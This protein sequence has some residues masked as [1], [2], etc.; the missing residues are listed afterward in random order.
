MHGIVGIMNNIHVS[1]KESQ[2]QEHGWND[3][4]L[5]NWML[6]IL[7]SHINAK[8]ISHFSQ[9]VPI[10]LSSWHSSLS[11]ECAVQIT[12]SLV[13]LNPS[14]R[15]LFPL[16]FSYL[17]LFNCSVMP[18][19]LQHHGM[20][21]AR[22]PCPSPSPGACSNSCLLSQWCHPT[23]LSSVIPFSSYLQSFPASGP[24]LFFSYLL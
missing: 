20:Q 18:N 22:L 13:I 8:V 11:R 19:S 3:C 21:H 4:F 1:A 12:V 17:L 16:F 6:L 24:F 7:A 14:V 23:I 10:D 9:M 15:A 5:T 2:G